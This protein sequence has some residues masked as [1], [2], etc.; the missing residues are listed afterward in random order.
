MFV[1]A[2][3]SWK[4]SVTEKAA[5]WAKLLSAVAFSPSFF[6]GL[7]NSF[8]AHQAVVQCTKLLLWIF[9]EIGCDPTVIAD[10]NIVINASSCMSSRSSP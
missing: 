6:Q 3:R 4:A 7:P 1:I 8:S 9:C 10:H 5:G 2:W